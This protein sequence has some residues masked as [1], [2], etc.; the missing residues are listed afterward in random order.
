VSAR[1]S[2]DDL[3]LG[4]VDDA[5]DDLAPPTGS[6]DAEGIPEIEGPLPGQER[7]DEGDEGFIPPGDSPWVVDRDDLTASGQRE[8]STLDERLSLEEPDRRSG[9]GVERGVDLIDA[10]RTD[11]EPELV[12]SIA[13][14]VE[15]APAEEAAMHVRDDAPGA[16]DDDDDGYVAEDGGMEP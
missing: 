7:A 3:D 10:D 14:T 15:G 9:D 16:T 5:T 13:A 6:L 8:G 12:G 2:D 4:D 11:D 1:S